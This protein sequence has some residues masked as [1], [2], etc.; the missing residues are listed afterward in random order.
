MRH[1]LALLLGMDEM[2]G[3]FRSYCQQV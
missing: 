1:E 3:L 2:T